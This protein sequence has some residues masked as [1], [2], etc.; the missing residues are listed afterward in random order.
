V[1]PAITPPRQCECPSLLKNAVITSPTTFP[2]ATRKK[3]GLLLDKYFPQS[4]FRGS[5][6]GKRLR[7]ATL[8]TS[9]SRGPRSNA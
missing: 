9:R 5:G 6:A 3:L 2:L 7:Q 4:T 1:I 8:G